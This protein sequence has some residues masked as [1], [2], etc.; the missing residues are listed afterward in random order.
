M[1]DSYG[2]AERQ[3]N[4]N[5]KKLSRSHNFLSASEVT[6]AKLYTV[7]VTSIGLLFIGIQERKLPPKQVI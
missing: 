2:G 7:Y 4:R 1:Y 6:I 3:T 5:R